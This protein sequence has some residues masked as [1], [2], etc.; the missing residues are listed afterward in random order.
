MRALVF[1][2]S[3]VVLAAVCHAEIITVDDDGPADFNNIQAAIDDAND[4]DTI[5]VKPGTYTGPGNYDLDFK[6]KAIT[7]QSENGPENCIIDC[8][9]TYEDPHRGFYF[10]NAETQNSILS[11]FTITNGRAGD[12]GG[13][14]CLHSNPLIT[15][16][17]IT[18]C[19]APGS[20]YGGGGI[21]CYQCSPLITNCLVSSC[22]GSGSGTLGSTGGGGISCYQ[23][24][25]LITDC[26]VVNCSTRDRGGGIYC[27]ESSPLITN[28]R[29]IACTA[30]LGGGVYASLGHPQLRDCT[31]IANDAT[32]YGG[33]ISIASGTYMT[34][35]NCIIS[36]NT[37]DHVGG[38]IYSSRILEL[39]VNN[40][41]FTGNKSADRGGAL[42]CR[43]GDILLTNCTL[44]GN[45]AL[46]TGGGI[47]A[48]SSNHPAKPVLLNSVLWANYAPLAS[49]LALVT[50]GDYKPTV[51]VSFSDLQ[52]G[53]S[54][55]YVEEGCTLNWDV[56]NMDVDPCFA[57]PGYWADPGNP[58]IP[59]EPNDP[60]AIW[61]DGDYH[62]RSH[63]WR[64]D[65]VRERW[66][67]DDVTSR[68]I[69]AGNPGSPLKEELLCIPDDP[70]NLWGQNLR[71]NMGA[72]GGTAE[73]GMAPYGWALLSDLTNDGIVD[74][75]DLLHWPQHW[76]S[77]RSELPSDLNR[78]HIVNMFDFALLA[79]D[80]LGASWLPT[81]PPL[82][83]VPSSPNPPH[84]ATGVSTSADLRWMPGSDATSHDVY[85]GI[86]D[87]PPF[88]RNQVNTTFDPGTMAFL[89]TYFW[90]I[91][92]L[93]QAGTT[94]G[95]VWTF[96]TTKPRCFAADTLVWVDGRL[97]QISKVTPG[98]KLAGFATVS[99]ES[100]RPQVESIDEHEGIFSE[101]YDIVLETG[102]TTTVV[103]S[104]FFLTASGQ[105]TRVQN[106]RPGCQLQS[107][108]GPITITNITHRPTPYVGKVYN[109][110]ISS[111]DYYFVGQNAVVVRDY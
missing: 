20:S 75:H 57:S 42:Y 77:S 72:Y 62:L 86:T 26:D 35:D 59:L 84:E 78:N 23:S 73:A 101:C 96:T 21:C 111:S 15:N 9:A 91:D 71:I 105:W 98:E 31:L 58:T 48:T 47:H 10:H 11:G 92:E 106:L 104:H 13:I 36:A 8:N 50:S 110:K 97:T 90:R 54:G 64:W 88:V 100:T 81:L 44:S 32:D 82:A 7:V 89:T 33:A 12:G 1:V 52:G 94:T 53:A 66:D 39:A 61:V 14:Y 27:Q 103:S 49:Q 37:V 95:P 24:N 69:D 46:T 79:Q 5:I 30:S 55:V 43:G 80:W 45:V 87:P 67:Y 65:T 28:C 38:A 108:T 63:G 34:I 70:D 41:L 4:G 56:G 107:L 76:L 109:L 83:G 102:N 22:T 25:P 74:T 18:D 68:C 3:S 19:H 2:I 60:K 17:V 51:S 40:T 29:I 85:F 6:G 93:N 99:T 16:C